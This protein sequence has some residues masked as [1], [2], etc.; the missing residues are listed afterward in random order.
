[1]PIDQLYQA[2]LII[3]TLNNLYVLTFAQ[4]NIIAGSVVTDESR[5]IIGGLKIDQV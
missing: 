3:D 5:Y 4:V 2:C 1:M